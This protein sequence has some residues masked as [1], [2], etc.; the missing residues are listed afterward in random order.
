MKKRK[1]MSFVIICGLF[2]LTG[3]SSKEVYHDDNMTA[4]FE[5]IVED[6][7]DLSID[8]KCST[9]TLPEST[10]QT[11][12][13]FNPVY[14]SF[15][16]ELSD[17]MIYGYVDG[18]LDDG[19]NI[20][21]KAYSSLAEL[22]K[23]LNMDVISSS[24][25]VYPEDGN[26]LVL[27]YHPDSMIF[28]NFASAK[29]STGDVS[30]IQFQILLKGTNPNNIFAGDTSHI[31]VDISENIRHE[32]LKTRDG[33]R[34]DAFVDETKGK[35]GIYLLSDACLYSWELDNIQSYD[36]VKSFVDSLE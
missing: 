7:L 14:E 20:Y 10:V 21:M 4:Y 29:T 33:L 16:I 17:G 13:T 6:R 9:A 34:V 2:L 31:V 27:Q 18:T 3:C 12:L 19:G 15:E 8:F 5:E 32:K 36:D 35:A 26:N 22:E 30:S 24:D 25:I 1:I 28:I 11:L 23:D